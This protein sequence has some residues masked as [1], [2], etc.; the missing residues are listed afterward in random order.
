MFTQRVRPV[1]LAANTLG[2]THPSV[3]P[4]QPMPSALSLWSMHS[5]AMIITKTRMIKG[6]FAVRH[7]GCGGLHQ[8]EYEEEAKVIDQIGICQ[9]V[10]RI[11]EH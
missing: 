4:A 6:P 10:A 8:L 9:R 1:P 5:T 3:C 11:N 2:S 7:R